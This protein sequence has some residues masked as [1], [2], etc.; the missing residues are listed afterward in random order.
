MTEVTRAWKERLGTTFGKK[1]SNQTQHCNISFANPK[2]VD[3]EKANR[4][5]ER[6]KYAD[7]PRYAG[8]LLSRRSVIV[9]FPSLDRNSI[10][11]PEMAY[12]RTMERGGGASRNHQLSSAGGSDLEVQVRMNK[13]MNATRLTV[14]LL[15][16]AVNWLPNPI[17]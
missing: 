9:E 5:R 12:Y 17:R 2:G 3:T 4:T 6:E 8:N 14:Y 13:L 16:A 7:C 15:H 11:V 10:S 1:V